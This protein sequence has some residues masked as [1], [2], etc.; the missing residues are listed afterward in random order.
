MPLSLWWITMHVYP[1]VCLFKRLTRKQQGVEKPKLMWTYHGVGVTDIKIY[2]SNG[3]QKFRKCCTTR[4]II[5][6]TWLTYVAGSRYKLTAWRVAGY[7]SDGN[8]CVIVSAEAWSSALHIVRSRTRLVSRSQ[9][10][11]CTCQ[12]F[13]GCYGYLSFVLLL[14][15]TVDWKRRRG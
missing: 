5:L 2:T 3:H 6:F 9:H 8:C 13:R 11:A 1:S 12:L 4:T 10:Q 14:M 15:P 7:E